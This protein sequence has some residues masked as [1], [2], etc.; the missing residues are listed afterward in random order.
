MRSIPHNMEIAIAIQA[1]IMLKK[2]TT[3]LLNLAHR[4]VVFQFS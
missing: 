3:K 4:F 1:A 2:V